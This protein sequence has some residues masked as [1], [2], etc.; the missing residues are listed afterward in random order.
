MT[1]DQSRRLPPESTGRLAAGMFI[2]SLTPMVYTGG[3]LSRCARRPDRAEYAA[4][5]SRYRWAYGPVS[6]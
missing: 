1:P 2:S 6:A 5:R 4:R 3:T